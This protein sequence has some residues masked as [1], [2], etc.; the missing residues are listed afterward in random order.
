MG[1]KNIKCPHCSFITYRSDKLKEH[2]AIQHTEKPLQ[3]ELTEDVQSVLKESDPFIEQPMKKKRKPYQRKVQQTT[4]IT[5]VPPPKTNA[6]C[7]MPQLTHEK[8]LDLSDVIMIQEKPE[9][10]VPVCTDS[11]DIL[12]GNIVLF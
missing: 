5:T 4:T 3:L 1:N 9:I 12:N 8:L 2:T 6:D 11:M 10:I 7:F